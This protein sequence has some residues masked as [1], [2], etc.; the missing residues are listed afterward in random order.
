MHEIIMAAS[1]EAAV[2]YMR[3]SASLRENLPLVYAVLFLVM[4]WAV[5]YVWDRFQ[6]TRRKEVP[7]E[8]SLFLELCVAHGLSQAEREVLKQA[9]Q[10]AQLQNCEMV[11]V[12]QR[13]LAGWSGQDA[14]GSAALAGLRG[15]LFGETRE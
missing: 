3:R 13:L 15:K 12:D 5:L 1:G 8:S 14:P 11:F 7:S 4:L 2:D 6:R 9:A 10:Q